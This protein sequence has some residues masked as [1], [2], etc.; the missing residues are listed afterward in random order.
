MIIIALT[1]LVLVV[2]VVAVRFS[3]TLKPKQRIVFWI[4][5][6]T[7]AA[8]FAPQLVKGAMAGYQKGADLRQQHGR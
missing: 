8:Y 1:V 7:A 2:G 4:V 3:L 5:V 6:I